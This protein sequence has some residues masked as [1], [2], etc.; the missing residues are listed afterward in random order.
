MLITPFTTPFLSF[1]CKSLHTN[2]DF[3]NLV[4]TYFLS[5]DILIKVVEK[6]LVYKGLMNKGL[7]HKGSFERQNLEKN[8]DTRV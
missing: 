3:F 2:A 1:I 5:S 8:N 7:C 4:L 6:S